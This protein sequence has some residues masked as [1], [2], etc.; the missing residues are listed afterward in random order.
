VSKHTISM[1]DRDWL[2]L[3]TDAIHASVRH[4]RPLSVSEYIRIIAAEARANEQSTR[5][6][7]Q[8]TGQGGR[9]VG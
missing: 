6:D 9:D 7:A 5:T 4:G 2:A 8:P 3:V 1:D